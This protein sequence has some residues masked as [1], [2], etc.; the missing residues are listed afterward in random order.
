MGGQVLGPDSLTLYVLA[1]SAIKRPTCTLGLLVT[2][3]E[4]DVD[5]S[6]IVS[7]IIFIEI[8]L[9]STP[10][11]DCDIYQ[12]LDGTSLLKYSFAH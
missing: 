5:K 7:A 8:Q 1:L 10:V 3:R 12:T 9:G 4:E 2:H 6:A 11:L